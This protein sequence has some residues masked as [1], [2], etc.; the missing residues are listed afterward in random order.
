[1]E[2]ETERREK[3]GEDDELTEV[4]NLIKLFQS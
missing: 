1:M 4:L 3:Q 2:K